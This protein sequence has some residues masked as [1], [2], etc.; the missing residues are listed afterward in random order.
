MHFS[1]KTM[2]H[3]TTITLKLYHTIPAYKIVMKLEEN[4]EILSIRNILDDHPT[5]KFQATIRTNLTNAQ[6]KENLK[7]MIYPQYS[8]TPVILEEIKAFQEPEATTPYRKNLKREPNNAQLDF[9]RIIVQLP[10]EIQKTSDQWETTLIKDYHQF[11]PLEYVLISEN[12]NWKIKTAFIRFSSTEAANEALKIQTRYRSKIADKRRKGNNASEE[13]TLISHEICGLTMDASILYL[14][15]RTCE[16]L[17]SLK[18]NTQRESK[19]PSR[20]LERKNKKGKANTKTKTRQEDTALINFENPLPRE[21]LY[22]SNEV[23]QI[24]TKALDAFSAITSVK[25]D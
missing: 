25:M 3:L 19:R 10:S 20:E 5:K 6:I 21:Q 16:K 15:V 4:G 8:A 9:Q 12:L 2:S 24:L 11:G 22:T 18:L 1:R 14:H 17:R 23:M 7:E 13:V